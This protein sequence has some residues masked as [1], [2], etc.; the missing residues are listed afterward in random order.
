MVEPIRVSKSPSGEIG[1][2]PDADIVEQ[3][4]HGNIFEIFRNLPREIKIE[5]FQNWFSNRRRELEQRI[6]QS[7]KA[8]ADAATVPFTPEA[9]PPHETDMK[10]SEEEG[11]ALRQAVAVSLGKGVSTR[12]ARVGKA[13]EGEEPE[14]EGEE[15]PLSKEELAGMAEELFAEW[16]EMAGQLTGHLIDSQIFQDLKTTEAEMKSEFQKWVRLAKFHGIGVEYVVLAA[17]KIHARKSG[18]ILTG[19]G[20]K[21]FNINDVMARVS[22]DLQSTS[23]LDFSAME[24]ARSVTQQGS[25]QMQTQMTNIQKIM[26]DIA[27]VIDLTHGIIGMLARMRNEIIQKYNAR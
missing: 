18:I 14:G 24:R 4:K 1:R 21:V 11:E 6:I 8:Y 22:S 15:E 23:G 20:K 13:A 12:R 9:F 27:G 5:D 16:E 17:A 26:Q 7:T 3:L 10:M 25:F 19:L 2:R